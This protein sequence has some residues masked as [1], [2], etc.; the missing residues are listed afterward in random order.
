METLSLTK[1][2]EKEIYDKNIINKI[3]LLKTKKNLKIKY[4]FNSESKNYIFYS[5]YKKIINVLEQGK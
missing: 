1:Y 4:L 2:E 5:C 3:P